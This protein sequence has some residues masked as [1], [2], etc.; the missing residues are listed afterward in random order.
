MEQE[1][2]VEQAVEQ[3]GGVKHARVSGAGKGRGAGRESRAGSGAGR[4]P[5]RNK[6]QRFALLKCCGD[7][8]HN[9]KNVSS[10]YSP[11]VL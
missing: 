4:G 6:N 3:A 5:T 10:G 8:N 7:I 1:G 9:F 2:R 11:P